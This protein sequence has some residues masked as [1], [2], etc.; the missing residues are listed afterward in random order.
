MSSILVITTGGTIAS[1][2]QKNGDVLAS[3]KGEDL[4]SKINIDKKIVV[5]NFST[6]N[7][8]AFTFEILEA[9]AA[10]VQSALTDPEVEGIV[11]THGTD[12]MEETAFFLALVTAPLK[13]IVLTGAQLDAGYPDSDGVRNLTEAIC[14][15]GC[16]EAAAWGPVIAFA[17]FVYAAR[18]V[19]KVDTTALAA[20]DSPGWGPLGRIDQ[21]NIM[22][23]RLIRQR[24][25][26]PLRKLRP[27]I[28]IR[29]ALGMTGEEILRI[30]EGYQGVVLDTFGRGNAHPS[31][32]AAAQELVQKDIPV[33]ITSRCLKG[34]IAAIYGNGGGQDLK[35]AGV[36]M[37][38][39]L[40]GEKA[41]L[42]FSLILANNL[43]KDEATKI[44]AEW[45]NP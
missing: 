35:R 27:V 26:L 40:S 19:L 7:S 9:L 15:A 1:L 31:V 11:I 4:I 43:A 37:A 39:D 38:G 44:I 14:V 12:T 23:G 10:E 36:W 34:C 29:L 17:G 42:L 32:F 22:I 2:P 25:Q 6:V 8:Y 24:K 33:V 30:A 28:L 41:R 18:E 16:K 3:L 20:F 21:K 5:K 13:P 45:A